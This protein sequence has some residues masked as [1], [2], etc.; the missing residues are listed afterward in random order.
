MSPCTEAVQPSA[1]PRLT[2]TPAMTPIPE[3]QLPKFS[4]DSSL[5]PAQHKVLALLADGRSIIDAA[6][7][8]GVHRNTVRNWRRALPAFAREAEWA[9][10]EQALAWH[11]CMVHLAPRAA[12]VLHHLLHDDSAAPALR[13]RAA[14]AVLKA[15]ADPQPKPLPFRGSKN[16]RKE[17][18]VKQLPSKTIEGCAQ[19]NSKNMHN[20]AQQPS[21]PGRRKRTH[22]TRNAGK[23]RPA[24]YSR[25]EYFWPLRSMQQESG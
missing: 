2:G 16:R 15:A 8:A 18:S 13:L 6:A 11:D 5:T 10:R 22:R 24:E 7:A 1:N 21:P 12:H 23:L 3:P 9:A 25:E 17:S 20:R 14:L 4:P 19:E